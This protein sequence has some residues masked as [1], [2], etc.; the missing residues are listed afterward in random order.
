MTPRMDDAGWPNAYIRG[1]TPD[2]EK[3][4]FKALG[5]IRRKDLLLFVK[6][7]TRPL[8]STSASP[9]TPFSQF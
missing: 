3:Q 8:S 5:L 6:Y 4:L 9:E 1:A 2:N 7:N